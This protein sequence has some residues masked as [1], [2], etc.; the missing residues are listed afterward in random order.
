MEKVFLKTVLLCFLACF[1][2]LGSAQEIRIDD[3]DFVQPMIEKWVTEYKKENPDSKLCV[4]TGSE[5][6]ETAPAISVIA[7]AVPGNRA[8]GDRV[9]YAGRYALIPVSNNRN[10][11]LERIGKGLKRNELRNLV[12]EKDPA[13]MEDDGD[14]KPKY[15]VTVYSRGGRNS[16][17]TLA[18]AGFFGASPE[19]IR[20]KKIIGDDIFLL[21][22]LQKDSNGIAFNTLNY[23]YNLKTR[24]L[25]DHLAILPLN[26]K[27]GQREALMSRNVDPVISIL[28]TSSIETIPV[29]K[30]GLLIPAAYADHE[31]VLRFVAWVTANGQRFNHEL[32]FLML[33]A[34]TLA[35][36]REKPDNALLTYA[37]AK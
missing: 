3:T 31:D 9:V 30:F 16:S 25:K 22:A 35:L 1:P 14:D 15:A 24:R 18:L 11:L 17:T 2:G 7:S 32:G 28:E 34:H 4:K 6:D 19:R 12:F 10:P 13:E 26:L 37:S 36:Q 8:N 29:E 27:S 5:K 21:H 23:V 20:G 33:D